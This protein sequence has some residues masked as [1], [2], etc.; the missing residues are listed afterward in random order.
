MS[1]EHE[2]QE[3]LEHIR[4]WWNNNRKWTIPFLWILIIAFIAY[5]GYH[6]YKIEQNKQIDQL[7]YDVNTAIQTEPDITKIIKNT[8]YQQLKTVFSDAYFSEAI[9]M[10][11]ATQLLK[12][13]K[14]DEAI[15]ELTPLSHISLTKS[16]FSCVAKVHLAG[17]LLEQKKYPQAIKELQLND[18]QK[19][20]AEPICIASILER[21]GDIYH[22]SNKPLEAKKQWELAQTYVKKYQMIHKEESHPLKVNLELKLQG[23]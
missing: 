3:Q 2:Q 23:T 20:E 9:V 19:E 17:A 11:V 10:K 21:L 15:K 14:Y 5:N 12:N 18:A 13:E 22:I 7:Y 6:Y 8:K 4:N 16:P 1:Y